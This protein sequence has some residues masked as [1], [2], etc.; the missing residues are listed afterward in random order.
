MKNTLRLPVG[1]EDF[2]EVRNEKF[3]YVDKTKLIEQL[4]ETTG[5]VNL[6]TRPRR[7]GKT[8]N[9]SMLRYFFEIGTDPKLFEGLYISQNKKLCDEY[10]G[11]FPV[12]FISLKSVDALI[13]ADA[14][15]QLRKVI[16]SEAERFTFLLDS[17][18]L[19]VN[20]KDKYRSLIELNNGLY[21]MNNNTT[22]DSLQLLSQL[23]YKH[24]GKKV[25][26]LVDEYDVPLA[27]AFSNGYYREM[28]ALI[29]AFLG[30]A[31]KT[32]DALYMA[33]LTGCLRISKESIFTG[34]NNFRV[35]SILDKRFDEQFGFTENEVKEL[36]EAYNLT[37]HLPEI[38]AWYDGYHF[39]DADIYCPWDVIGYV[40]SLR[41]NP[42]AKPQ[43]YWINTSSN[44]L[45][46]RFVDKADKTTRDEIEKLV[47]GEAIEKNLRLELTYDE[48][49]TS[50]D[51]LWSVLFTTGYLT[52]VGM[53]EDGAYKLIIP[54]REIC[55]VYKLQI[56][57][58]F[59]SSL[60]KNREQIEEFWQAFGEGRA[61]VVQKYLNRT[62]SNTI[63]IFDTK[64]PE[65]ERFYHAFLAGI[66]ICNADFG[67][68]SNREGGN[69]FADLLITPDDPDAGIVVE[70]KRAE[71]LD[72]LDAACQKA[73]EQIHERSYADYFRNEGRTDIL[74][75][76]IAF[77]KKRCKVV[78]ERV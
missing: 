34:L 63:S 10:L 17:E 20:E 3:Y 30:G 72:E 74:S 75:Y 57:E 18:R 45:V 26:I 69:G 51:N 66:L 64:K 22:A 6:F 73:M 2:S 60:T 36:L 33:V 62:L 39:G 55:E 70:I 67:V 65:A 50:I 8:L 43:A 35:L 14:E 40:D 5:K 21:A 27:K 12:I 19:N 11:K 13:F 16:G 25:I 41:A 76:G 49:D 37:E 32:N 7:F 4:F 31:L 53:T 28:V 61:D 38:K 52:H 77:W 15:Y 23:L 24:Y 71:K 42:A 1:Y 46:K 68:R 78:V 29:R 48:L 54:N 9:M 56:Q 58:W 59:K 44:D 47:A